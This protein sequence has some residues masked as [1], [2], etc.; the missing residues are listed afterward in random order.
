MALRRSLHN[1]NIKAFH[2]AAPNRGAVI[3]L[4]ESYS[5]VLSGLGYGVTSVRYSGVRCGY[6]FLLVFG[7]MRCGLEW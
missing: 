1:V 3:L 6:Y 7:A 4:A 5:A 2:G